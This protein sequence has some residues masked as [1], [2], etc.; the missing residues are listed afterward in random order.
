MADVATFDGSENFNYS[1][2]HCAA[3]LRLLFPSIKVIE[4]Q[5]AE[6]I[7]G[8]EETFFLPIQYGF[9]KWE[10]TRF[11]YKVARDDCGERGIWVHYCRQ[12]FRGRRPLVDVSGSGKGSGEGD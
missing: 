7:E 1:V 5:S 12:C 6:C 3:G 8:Q 2:L 4:S 10:R 11:Y 9:I